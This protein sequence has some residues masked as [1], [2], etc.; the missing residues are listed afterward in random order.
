MTEE[1]KP[2]DAFEPLR[3]AEQQIKRIIERVLKLESERLYQ[4]APH[5]NDDVL[6]IV[7]EEVK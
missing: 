7:K 3:T 4:K 1:E 2:A 5:L 6:R